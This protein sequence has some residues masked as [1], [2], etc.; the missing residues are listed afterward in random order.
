VS[1][2]SV[3]FF[4]RPFVVKQGIVAYKQM[5]DVW[6]GMVEDRIKER[7]TIKKNGG[8]PKIYNGI[9]LMI[10]LIFVL[11]VF[12]VSFFNIYICMYIYI[13]ICRHDG[14]LLPRK[15]SRRAPN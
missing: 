3:P 5:Q 10:C 1:G 8:Q 2:Y 9:P 14:I 4:I 12:I 6:R 13:N 11:K 15:K 7:D